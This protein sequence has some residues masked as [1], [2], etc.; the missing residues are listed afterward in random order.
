MA[1]NPAG[2]LSAELLDGLK[3]ALDHMPALVCVDGEEDLAVIPLVMMAPEGAL[4]LYG[5]P[6]EGIVLRIRR[7]PG[8]TK[9]WR[10]VQVL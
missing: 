7:S 4:I 6:G 1:K 2:T 10:D 9:S 3:E 5:Q 8:K